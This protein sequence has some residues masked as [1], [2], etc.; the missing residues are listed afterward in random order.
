MKTI[1]SGLLSLAMSASLLGLAGCAT[2]REGAAVGAVTG[3]A[4]GILAAGA[5]GGPHGGPGGPHGGGGDPLGAAL[6]GAGIGAIVGAC[7]GQ[8]NQ[9]QQQQ[10]NARVAAAEQAARQQTVWVNNSNRSRTP[11]TLTQGTGGTWIGP[12]G[13]AYTT[14]PTQEQLKPLYGF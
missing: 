8:E 9:E 4:V 1:G 5:M 3:A 7:I 2:P 13:E 10:V 6:L 11:V 14:M 12:K